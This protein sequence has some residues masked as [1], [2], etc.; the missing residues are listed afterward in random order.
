MEPDNVTPI[1]PPA[2]KRPRRAPGPKIGLHLRESD[3]AR[4]NCLDLVNALNGVCVALDDHIVNHASGR[5]N[6]SCQ[7]A[8]AAMVLS[9]IVQDRLEVP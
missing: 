9:S 8:T 4:F 1:R 2:K 6:H 7:L 3:D 5:D